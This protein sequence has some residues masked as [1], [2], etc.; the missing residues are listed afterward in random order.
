MYKFC[1]RKK[2]AKITCEKLEKIACITG[3]NMKLK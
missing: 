3:N 1:A 2:L